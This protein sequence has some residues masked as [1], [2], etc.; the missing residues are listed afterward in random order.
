MCDETS[1]FGGPIL[2][3]SDGESTKVGCILADNYLLLLYP[4]K[5]TGLT[6]NSRRVLSV[7]RLVVTPLALTLAQLMNPRYTALRTSTATIWDG[8]AERRRTSTFKMVDT[9]QPDYRGRSTLPPVALPSARR[10]KRRLGTEE[11]EEHRKMSAAGGR[12]RN[13]CNWKA[14]VALT[15]C[16]A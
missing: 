4:T 8:E 16:K 10:D 12:Y 13:K 11:G 14:R 2:L 1:E 5:C 9:C 6:I 3:N 7:C 15:R